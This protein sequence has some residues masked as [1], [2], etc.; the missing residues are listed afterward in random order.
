MF[1]TLTANETNEKKIPLT[2]LKFSMIYHNLLRMVPIFF[3]L[4]SI[5]L[6]LLLLLLLFACSWD[7]NISTDH[8]AN[9]TRTYKFFAPLLALSVGA[10]ENKEPSG[11]CLSV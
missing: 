1:G 5:G 2:F 8:V 3:C 6:L 4:I 7:I 10:A 9:V 11:V